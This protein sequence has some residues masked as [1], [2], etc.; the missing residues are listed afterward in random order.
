MLHTK[1][2]YLYRT[3]DNCYINKTQMMICRD[4]FY[5]E[6]SNMYFCYYLHVDLLERDEHS[7]KFAKMHWMIDSGYTDH[8]SPFLDDFVCLRTAKCSTTIA[9]DRKVS[10][11]V[12]SRTCTTLTN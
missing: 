9:N 7:R 11:Y 5:D 2:L 12:Q 1:E 6:E 3:E 8:L 4:T 10:I